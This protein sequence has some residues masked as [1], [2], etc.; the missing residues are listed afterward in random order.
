[1]K[2][3]LRKIL[4]A[5]MAVLL[6]MAFCV[7]ALADT[8]PDDGLATRGDVVK[9]LY[10]DYGNGA[11]AGKASAFTDVTAESGAIEAAAWAAETGV[12][13]GYG[14][15]RFGPEDL[16]TRE[17][18]ATML[19]RYAQSVGQ[20]FKGM[21]M[22]QLDEPDASEIS[23]WADEAMHWVVMNKVITE[24]ETGLAPK[25]YIGINELPVWIRN[26]DTALSTTLENGGYTLKIPVGVAGQLNTDL[27]E[28]APDGTL[29]YVS[30]QA[31]IDAAKAK[32]YDGDGVGWLFAI[33][34]IGE[35]EAHQILCGD[36]SGMQIFAKDAE[37]GYFLFCTP[38]DVRFDRETAEQMTADA[39]VWA[40]LN[41]WAA[42]AKDSFINENGLTLFSHG[43]TPVD[44]AL[45]RVAYGKNVNYTLSTT[46]FGPLE[47]LD[48]VDAASYVY[49]VLNDVSFEYVD[50]AEGPDG[51]YVVLNFPDE[52]VRFD[53]FIADGNLV[54]CVTESGYEE[55]YRASYPAEAFSLCDVMQEWYT[56]LAAA[57]GKG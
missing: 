51:E 27:P 56:V 49:S 15:G 46:A 54:R 53:F 8:S 14:D 4:S 31:S 52:G 18:A 6:A 39:Q 48:S 23:D 9:W 21:W 17:Q 55:Y 28:N 38:T 41:E 16:V 26:L 19:Y 12:A 3:T 37:G 13:K 36:M 42:S 24:R 2:N 34:K 40:A 43:N 50:L 33:R 20:G 25:D 47:P 57:H 5:A 45:Y 22:F 10:S 7:P 44:I 29:F 1:M 30:E 32:G 35:E 11:A